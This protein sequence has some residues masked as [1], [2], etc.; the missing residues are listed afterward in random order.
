M[1]IHDQKNL[2]I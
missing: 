1:T 2:D